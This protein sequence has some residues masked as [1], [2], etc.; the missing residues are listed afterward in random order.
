MQ[1]ELINPRHLKNQ[2]NLHLHRITKKKEK[3]RRRLEAIKR[4]RAPPPAARPSEPTENE[5][6][7]RRGARSRAP[8][9]KW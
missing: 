7:A 1:T 4:A 3:E 9:E 5:S 8:D 6:R 2:N